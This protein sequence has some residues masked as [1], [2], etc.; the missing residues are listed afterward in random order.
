MAKVYN[1]IQVSYLAK[2]IELFPIIF[3]TNLNLFFVTD[4]SQ[5]QPLVTRLI[6]C[7]LWQFLYS[8][9]LLQ[10]LWHQTTCTTPTQ[11]MEMMI[12]PTWTG[13]LFL[14]FQVRPIVSVK[15][16]TTREALLALRASQILKQVIDYD[17][18]YKT[19]FQ[20]FISNRSHELKYIEPNFRCFSKRS[21]IVS[22]HTPWTWSR[23]HERGCKRSRIRRWG[24]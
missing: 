12:K 22:K 19:I 18:I 14:D 9:P 3:K 7:H 5:N 8:R 21:R 11:N 2:Y 13:L 6:R 23:H 17:M 20:C 4:R 24:L 15:L 10:P 16:P 1:F